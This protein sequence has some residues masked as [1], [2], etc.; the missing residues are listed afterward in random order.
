V[1]FR[2]CDENGTVDRASNPNGSARNIAGICNPGRNV[3]GMMPHPER[4][5]STMLGN[6]DGRKIIRELIM[7]TEMVG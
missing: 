5:C 4:A 3:F 2:Y 7:A 6:T 1:I